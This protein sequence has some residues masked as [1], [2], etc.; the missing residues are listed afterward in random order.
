[1]N[2]PYGYTCAICEQWVPPNTMHVCTTYVPTPPAAMPTSSC[3]A[4]WVP[5]TADAVRLIVREELERALAQGKKD[6]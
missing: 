4:S 3:R 6:D 5:L 2:A 1:M